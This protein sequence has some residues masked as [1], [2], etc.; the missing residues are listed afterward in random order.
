MDVHPQPGVVRQIPADVVGIVVNRDRIAVPEPAVDEGVIP[1]CDAEE[2]TIEP[3]PVSVSAPQPV[4]VPE[5]AGETPVL[6]RMIEVVVSV[7]TAGIVS[8]PPAVVVNV[9]RVGMPR[10]VT[11]VPTSSVMRSAVSHRGG[12][13]TWGESTTDAVHTAATTTV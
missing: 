1:G 10:L 11:K 3:E 7:A 5:P 6:I 9:R 13:V 4:L 2:E 12:T 8:D